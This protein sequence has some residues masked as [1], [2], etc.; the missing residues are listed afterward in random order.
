M[1]YLPDGMPLP[2][3]GPDDKPYWDY[4]R[5][6]EL[7][8]QTCADCGKFRHPPA[9]ACAS[10]GSFTTKWTQVSGRG[11]VYSYT[12]AR[13][14]VYRA[15][16][17]TP[18]YNIAVIMMEGADDVRIVSNVIDAQPDEIQIGLPVEL[19]WE[20]TSDGGFLPRFRKA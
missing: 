2:Q 1:G 6:R 18:P 8:F 17:Q 4:C 20:S 16:K 12:V 19:L 13:H 5:Q 7:R 10:C 3:F 14:P 11:T 15:L 9:P